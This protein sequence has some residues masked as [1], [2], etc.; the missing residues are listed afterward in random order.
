V[1]S[2]KARERSFYKYAFFVYFVV[3]I[4]VVLVFKLQFKENQTK[5]KAIKNK[6]LTANENERKIDLRGGGPNIS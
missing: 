6:L 1:P 4:G 2:S 5:P 3:K